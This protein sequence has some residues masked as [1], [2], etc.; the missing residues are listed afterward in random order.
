MYGASKDGTLTVKP[1]IIQVRSGSIAR[2]IGYIRSNGSVDANNNEAV[3]I[4]DGTA[5]VDTIVA[6]SASGEIKNGNVGIYIRGGTVNK[7]IGGCQGFSNV[8][9]PYT[10]KTSINISGGTVN[11]VYGAGSG[12]ATGIP[13]YQG[14]LDIIVTGGSISS[15]YGS[16]SAAYVVSGEDATK[17][18]ISVSAGTVGNIYAAGVGGEA[19]VDGGNDVN[20]TPAADFGSLTGKADITIDNDAVIT[21]NIYA[22]GQGYTQ[23]DYGKGNAYLDG[24]AN[25]TV[26][27][28]TIKGNIYGGGEGVN[29]A[30]FEKSARVCK[31]SKVTVEIKGGLIE[32][33]VYGGGKVAEVEG[34][35]K[36]I[37]SGGTIKGNVYGGGEAG[38]TH[39]RAAVHMANGTVNGSI[40]GGALGK[41]GDRFVYGGSTVNMTGGWVRGNVYGGSELS[42]DG[43][44]GEQD[45]KSASGL[46]FVNL[47]GGTVSGKVFGGGFQGIVNGSTHVHIGLGAID[48][49]NYYKSH[50]EEKPVLDASGLSVG[51]SVYA[52][53]DYGGDSADLN[54]DTITVNG[55]SHVYIDGT[56]YSFGAGDTG[57]K[58][59]RLRAVCLEAVHPAT[60]VMCVW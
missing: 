9:A 18:N 48:K 24:E 45:E 5:K 42:N 51:G 2:I 26:N 47:T 39:G 34:S 27:G 55:F 56:D 54:Y 52:G 53:G 28:G 44:S 10:G 8:K 49:C 46:V 6:G 25:I 59:W 33:Y 16:G 32:G 40:Y 38:L 14:I 12:R 50:A 13:T 7:I 1:G 31:N 37:I 43:K 22:S 15:I 21:G 36:V 3:I 57:G 23:K 11:M 4:V 58:R 60:L 41:V 19:G 35:T 17:V 29:K 20:G 30:G